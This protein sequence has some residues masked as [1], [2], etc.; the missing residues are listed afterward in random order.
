VIL[1]QHVCN[2]SLGGC[3]GCISYAWLLLAESGKGLGH[4]M[5]A[6]C[7][8]LVYAAVLAA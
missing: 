6:G 5:L 7:G 3:C 8:Q 4:A 1:I 2:G